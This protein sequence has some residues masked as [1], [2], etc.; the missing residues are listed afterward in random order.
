M[1]KENSFFLIFWALLLP[2]YIIDTPSSSE[3]VIC[4]YALAMPMMLGLFHSSLYPN[5]VDKTLFLCPVGRKW[6]RQFLYTAYHFRIGCVMITSFLVGIILLLLGKLEL[7]WYLLGFF[8]SE[9]IVASLV[10]LRISGLT[11]ENAGKKGMDKYSSYVVWEVFT[12]MTS[13][14]SWMSFGAA[15]IEYEGEGYQNPEAAA[16]LVL[17][18]IQ[19]LFFLKIKISYQEKL[20]EI[21]ADY[22]KNCQ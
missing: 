12:W 8:L 4:Y 21:A 13:F 2:G 11:W 20:M 3:P 17:L 1:G 15:A 10:F 16:L 22:E 14:L 6:I 7:S 9:G 18:I 19:V 5:G